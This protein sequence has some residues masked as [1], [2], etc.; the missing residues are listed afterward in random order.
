MRYKAIKG[1]IKRYN[2]P[3]DQEKKRALGVLYNALLARD[4]LVG[5]RD[6]GQ[7]LDVKTDVGKP[8]F[9]VKVRSIYK[10]V[11]TFELRT[12]YSDSVIL[13]DHGSASAFEDF[14]REDES[15]GFQKNPVS[16][17]TRAKHA[18]LMAE[19]RYEDA[20]KVYKRAMKRKKNP[21]TA[22]LGGTYIVTHA[23]PR[24]APSKSVKL[25]FASSSAA[26]EGMRKLDDAG[27]DAGYPS[28][29]PATFG[30][31]K[32]Y[33]TVQVGRKNAAAAQ[34]VVGG[35]RSNPATLKWVRGASGGFRADVGGNRAYLIGRAYSFGGA[36]KGYY[37]VSFWKGYN[38]SDQRTVAKSI[39]GLAA[40][41]EA[42]QNDY[43]NAAV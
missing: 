40:A 6:G 9:S 31:H 41:K 1:A 37:S 18:A 33:Y 4:L 23:N 5:S 2:P 12:P 15:R 29:G 7:R 26:W 21:L 35:A 8:T 32:G 11:P 17:R 38:G 43:N 19:H 22:G 42:A 20:A 3:S 16:L 34:R 39:K 30:P 13:F 36:L 27:I 24:S 10:G 25:R 14:I 28:L